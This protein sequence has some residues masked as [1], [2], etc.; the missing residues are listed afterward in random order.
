MKKNAW[1]YY[2]TLNIIALFSG[3]FL[4]IYKERPSLSLVFV[5]TILLLF[6]YSK[7]FKRV[8]LVGN[9][10]VSVIITFVIWIVYLFDFNGGNN[11]SG[12]FSFLSAIFKSLFLYMLVVYYSV[13]SF[14]TTLIREIIKDIE[15]INGDYKMKMKTLPIILGKKRARNIAIFFSTILAFFLLISIKGFAKNTDTQILAWYLSILI[16]I[17]MLFFIYKLWNA[18]TKKQ[19]HFLSNLMKLIML[20]GI[21]S[22]GLFKFM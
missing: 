11:S 5:I 3:I 8:P 14:T 4:S 18:K 1:L 19:Y 21:L 6:L 2:S 12:F 17:P 20:L 15:D 22:M 7:Y 16:C 10:I 9:I 13:F